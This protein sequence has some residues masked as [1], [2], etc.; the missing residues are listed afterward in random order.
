MCLTVFLYLCDGFLTPAT[1]SVIIYLGHVIN[2]HV[3]LSTFHYY[4]TLV[5]TFLA[6]SLLREDFQG[7]FSRG[8]FSIWRLFF[9]IVETQKNQQPKPYPKPFTNP[10]SNTKL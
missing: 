9:K 2:I 6:R 5:E 1:S 8:R 3:Q 10:N 4:E 7:R